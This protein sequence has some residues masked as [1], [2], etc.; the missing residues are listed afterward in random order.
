[1]KNKKL[2]II[3]II[4]IIL[5]VLGAGA[6]AIIYFQTDLFKSPKQLFFKYL[7]KSIDF[8]KEFDYDRFL[9]EYKEKTEKSYTSN[10]ELTASLNY[11]ESENI[12][13]NNDNSTSLNVAKQTEETLANLKNS[14]SNTKI[15]YSQESIPTKQKYHMSIKPIYKDTEITNLELLS[16]DDNY[17]VKCTDLYDKYIYIENNNLKAFASKF[18][19]NSSMINIIPDKIHKINPYE[20]LYVSPEIRNQISEKYTK[21]LDKK[22]TKDMFTTQKNVSISVNDENIQANSY[23]LT[24]NGE[25][26][27]DILVSFLQ[28]LK[29]DDVTL[30]LIIQK[31]EQ[32][33]MK[34][35]F[36]TS[37][38]SSS[39]SYSL[40]TNSNNTSKKSNITLDT[41]YLKEMIQEQI[42]DLEDDK[43]SFDANEKVLFTVYSYKGK[44]VKLEITNSENTDKIGMDIKTNKN[45]KIIILNYNDT[46]IQ[47]I[48]YSASK[49]KTNLIFHTYDDDG[50]EVSVITADYGKNNTKLN[51]KSEL[52]DTSFEM[53]IDSNGEI[54]K[55]TVNT[56]GYLDIHTNGVQFKLNINQ[57]KNY[58]DNV[59]IDDLTANNG[60]LL[61]EMS[62][63]KM[64]SLFKEISDKFQ[65]VLPE[66]ANLLEI[67]I[68][69]NDE[70]N[71]NNII[72]Q[73]DLNGYSVYT[74][75][76]GVQFAYPETWKSLGTSSDKPVFSSL[77]NKS[78][79]NLLSETVT[80]EYNLTSYMDALISNLK[81]QMSNKI[82]GDINKQDVKLN[83]RDASI[84]TYT[85]IQNNAKAKIKQTCF[86]DNNT[87]YVLTAATFED[88]NV[89]SAEIIDNIISSFKK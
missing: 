7:G 64:I 19:L 69:D 50:N 87:A 67:K 86:I 35:S 13:S 27:Y 32:S 88:N 59:N 82:D 75:P 6:S 48:N 56:I 39:S 80:T 15:Q 16:S 51:L 4:L 9:A 12:L 83:G 52:D 43:S 26:T 61:N 25:Q 41:N 85:L 66:K 20:L 70:N 36:E 2:I 47:K 81:T 33:G 54:G 76:S 62:N 79:V 29:E 46:T 55:G 74:H 44:T 77:D 21:L 73:K 89:Q 58:T 40:N 45:E 14:L 49:D 34:E 10:G 65:K 72:N 57:N 71:D 63:T 60:E 24:L 42:N 18:G 17:G 84:I 3:P 38:N 53:N 37:F 23:T 11:K 31:I 22:L 28:E 1:M 8:D 5:L 30:D 68:P 78:N